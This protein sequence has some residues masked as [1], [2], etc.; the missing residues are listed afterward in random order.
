MTVLPQKAIATGLA[1]ASLC[2]FVAAGSTPAAAAWRGGW[3][4]PVAAGVIAGAAVGA[5]AAGAVAPYPYYYGP[6][7]A[8]APAPACWFQRQPVFDY[9]GRVV[10]YRR[11]RVCQ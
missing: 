7:V 3:G 6:P 5:L 1:A 8:Y 11:V 2:A 4:A 9:Y 10:G